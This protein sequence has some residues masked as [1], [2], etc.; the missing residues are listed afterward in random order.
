MN[1]SQTVDQLRSLK[2]SGMA[3]ALEHQMGNPAFAK[4]GFAQRMQ[5]LVDAELA[6]RDTRR[7]DRIIKNAKLK[8][9]A[10]PEDIEYKSGRGLDKSVMADLLTLSWIGKHKNV[11]I[12]GATGTGK[13]WVA[14]A[15][16]VQAARQG[17][18]VLYKRVPR[19]LEDL[20]FARDDGSISKLRSQFAKAQLL[21]L[22]DFGVTQLNNRGRTDLLELLDDRVDVSSTIVAAQLPIKDWHGH[23]ND[24][25]LADAILDRLIY[26]SV[27]LDLKGESMRKAKARRG[28]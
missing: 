6:S 17:M 23:I 24:P 2:L 1:H 19:V 20:T 8:V 18:T 16:G 12:N 3:E 11:L 26:G 4:L 25:A 5:D 28:A 7:Y 9:L 13:T 21:I 15:L 14:C 27:K 10:A 22:D